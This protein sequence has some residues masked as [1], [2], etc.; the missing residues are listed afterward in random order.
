MPPGK[1]SGGFG[2]DFL[3]WLFKPR[4]RIPRTD[5]AKRF[6]LIGRTGQGSMSKV[7]RARDSKTGQIVALKVL[8]KVK[9]KKFEERFPGLRKP[10]EGVVA[11]SLKHPNIVRTLEYGMTM[12]DEPFLVMEFVDG[13]G[14]S[15]LVD[16]QNE[17][18][19]EFR[20]RYILQLGDA[21]RYFHQQGW[22]HR[23]ICPR[24]V[25]VK[26]DNNVKLIDFGLAVPNTPPFQAPGNR[27][28]TANYM[29]P[30]LIKRLKTDQRIDIYSFSVSCFEMFTRRYPW[31]STETFE[32]A[33]QR[34]N[35]TPIS[36]LK[37]RPNMDRELAEVIMRGL[38]VQPDERW[39]S[40]SEMLRPL[41]LAAERLGATGIEL[42]SANVE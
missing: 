15:L 20:L 9:T 31:E 6:E 37:V 27:T 22:I 17:R 32:A 2:L 40:M 30:E 8:D 7:W 12:D 16:L 18:M 21:V 19:E 35:S 41:R 39:Q 5:I 10:S 42:R 34:M 28:G 1:K 33:R 14:L 3:S 4:S 25:L 11:L 36:I 26:E 38:A 23:D 24:N 13:V 29:A